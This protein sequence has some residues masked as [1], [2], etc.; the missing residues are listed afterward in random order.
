MCETGIYFEPITPARM[1][2]YSK[3]VQE[4]DALLEKRKLILARTGGTHGVDY[5]RLRVTTG[6]GNRISEEEYCAMALQKVNEEINF[7]LFKVFGIYGLLQEHEV[8]KTQIGRVEDAD[9]RKLLI[10]RY[11]EKWKWSEISWEFFWQEA[12]FPLEEHGKYH[13]KIHYWHRQALKQLEKIS[14]TPYVP[15]LP[16]QMIITASPLIPQLEEQTEEKEQ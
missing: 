8:I 2:D 4:L 7:Y 9:Y 12:D 3:K 16:R 5:S 15:V 1:K 10:L 14:S 13:D 6:N 11:L